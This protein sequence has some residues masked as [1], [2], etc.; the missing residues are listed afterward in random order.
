MGIADDHC[1]ELR[2]RVCVHHDT[3]ENS[4]LSTCRSPSRPRDEGTREPWAWD[5]PGG[6]E[7]R[8]LTS[9]TGRQA[10]KGKTSAD[11][12]EA[13][14]KRQTDARCFSDC[15]LETDT[16]PMR[17]RHQRTESVHNKNK[18]PK[19]HVRQEYVKNNKNKKGELYPNSL[20]MLLLLLLLLSRFSRV[21]LCATP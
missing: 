4:T 8:L 11:R 18:A 6:F 14:L 10:A 9:G 3:A 13:H 1:R 2:H 15:G 20:A 5:R 16:F 19:P 17:Q 12:A 7:L 21:Q